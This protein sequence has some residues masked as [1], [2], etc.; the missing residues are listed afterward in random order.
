MWVP[1][2]LCGYCLRYL[3][4]VLFR[5]PALVQKDFISG[6]NFEPDNIQVL[7]STVRNPGN[8]SSVDQFIQ[9]YLLCISVVLS[10]SFRG[11]HPA[12]TCRDVTISSANFDFCQDGIW[13]ELVNFS[14]SLWFSWITVHRIHSINT[15]IQWHPGWKTFSVKGD[16]VR[17]PSFIHRTCLH[18]ENLPSTVHRDAG[19]YLTY[20]LI[21]QSVTR[22]RSLSSKVPL[23]MALPVLRFQWIFPNLRSMLHSSM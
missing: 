10:R 6:R 3:E 15:V 21:I 7:E 22:K 5:L 13:Y 4:S 8:C 20:E 19:L 14:P 17:I 1:W 16:L 12:L 23:T 11:W 2:V 9:P 18:Q